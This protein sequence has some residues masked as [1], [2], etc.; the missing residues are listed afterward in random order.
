MINYWRDVRGSTNIFVGNTLTSVNV[1]DL[2]I[3]DSLYIK[4]DIVQSAPQQ[5]G[6]LQTI[7]V[8]PSPNFSSIVYQCPAPAFYSQAV[9]TNLTATILISIVD[10]HD[11]VINLNGQNTTM[12]LLFYRE[13]N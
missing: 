5:P 13:N 3:E 9:T 4:S 11:H 10:E 8:A 2:N 1:A 6:I 7:K 12:T